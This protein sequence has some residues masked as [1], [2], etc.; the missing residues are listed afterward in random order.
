MTGTS[1]QHYRIG[2]RLGAGAMGEVYLA[3]D[4]RLGR[5]VALK[6]PQRAFLLD[7][8]ARARLLN[9]ARAA[10]GLRSPHIAAIFDIIDESGVMAIV[11]EYVEGEALSARI[12]RGPLPIADAID[13][14]MQVADAL[15]EAHTH[16][17]VHRD[18]KSANLMVTERGRVKMLDF[19]L[20][21]LSD[22]SGLLDIGAETLSR[23]VPGTIKGTFYYMSPEQARGHDVDHRTDLF[24]L[25]VILYEMLTGRLPFEGATLTDVLDRIL[26]QPPPAIARF[27]QGV[28]PDLETIVLKALHKDPAFRY[29]T[30]R[31]IYVDLHGVRQRAESTHGSTIAGLLPAGRLQPD[32]GSAPDAGLSNGVAVMTFSNITREAADE[33]IGSGIAETVTADLQNIH[34]LTVLPRA[35]IF[36]ALRH[37]SSGALADFNER[38]G[39][40]IGRKLAAAWIVGG[41]FQR[42]G[43]R[44]R[45]TAQLIDV[46]TGTLVRTVKIDGLVAELFSLQDRIVYELSQGLNLELQQSEITDIEKA[47]TRSIDAYEA[48]TRGMMNLRMAGRDSLDRAISLFE[49]ALQ[50]DPAYASAWAGLGTAYDLKGSFL[51]LPDVLEKAV[52]ALKRAIELNPRLTAAHVRISGSYVAL[53]RYEEALVA[54]GDALRLDPDNDAAHAQL[55]RVHWIGFGRIDDAITELEHVTRVNPEAGYSYLQL[56]LLYGFNAD[57]ERAERAALAAADLQER[58]LSGREGLLIV[59]A[60]T[61]LGYVYYLQGRYEE[62]I[63]EYERELT[64]LS[65]SDHALKERSLIELHQ[66]LGAVY[67]RQGMP[68]MA[69]EYFARAVHGFG[70]LVLRG[71]GDPATTY[72]MACLYALRGEPEKALGYLREV[73]QAL[74]AL[75]TVRARI[76]PDLD[77]LRRMP[78]FEA[79][80]APGHAGS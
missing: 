56:A 41:G 48:Y 70:T 65:S 3:D 46:R 76:D 42:L 30:A 19:G 61:R 9:E 69:E 71:A 11:M 31:D 57:Y 49:R 68:E 79:L 13:I 55:A 60:H 51:T 4:T 63:R 45:I 77:S 24:A 15:E 44:I 25:G 35:H 62:A 67:L 21:K 23:T 73:V 14:G 29:Q 34:G 52:T 72:Y 12:E 28:T 38:V 54:V 2:P 18:V 6:V 53:G 16:G 1:L 47:E 10:S 58:Y 75:N 66:K 37:L 78:Q 27:N 7:G 43:D 40:E 8:Q 33:W 50:R 26:H 80:L 39:I 17:V 74:R 59:G 36:E 20:A 22:A 64:F 32:G 5:Q